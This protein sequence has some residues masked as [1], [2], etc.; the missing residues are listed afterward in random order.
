LHPNNGIWVS[1]EIKQQPNS[2][3]IATSY[4]KEKRGS[5]SLKGPVAESAKL[6]SALA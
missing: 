3:K 6:G 5:I 1:T 4:G 2:S